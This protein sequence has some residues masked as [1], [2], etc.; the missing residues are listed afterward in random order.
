MHKHAFIKTI[1][2][3][4]RAK[5]SGKDLCHKFLRN[6]GLRASGSARSIR[7][8]L[9]QST[10]ATEAR[11]ELGLTRALEAAEELAFIAVSEL[12]APVFIVVRPRDAA[13]TL[14]TLML[15]EGKHFNI[16]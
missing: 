6:S 15:D 4:L 12:I 14:M 13:A 16:C 8:S 7:T 11:R 5:T 3:G 1:R 10:V 9:Q 2:S